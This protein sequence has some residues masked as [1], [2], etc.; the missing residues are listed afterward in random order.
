M[1]KLTARGRKRLKASQFALP[2]RRYPIFDRRHARAALS[3]G[4][5]HLSAKQYAT[6]KRK[7]HAKFPGIHIAGM[8]SKHK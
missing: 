4:A 8:K 5:R 3:M 2:G 7:V 1:S 6:V